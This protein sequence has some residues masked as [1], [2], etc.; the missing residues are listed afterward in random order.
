MFLICTLKWAL[1]GLHQFRKRTTE[2]A[3]WEDIMNIPEILW[4]HVR[5]IDFQ[6]DRHR[7]CKD[8]RDVFTDLMQF[9][10]GECPHRPEAVQVLQSQDNGRRELLCV[11]CNQDLEIKKIVYGLKGNLPTAPRSA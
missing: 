8:L 4:R 10:A 11:Y 6:G 3:A 5:H 9:Q 7:V 2:F 1:F